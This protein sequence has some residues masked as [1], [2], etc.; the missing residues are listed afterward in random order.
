M[1]GRIEDGTVPGP[2]KR[3]VAGLL[4]GLTSKADSALVDCLSADGRRD[5]ERCAGAE[6][7]T[8]R[9]HLSAR[10]HAGPV[11]EPATFAQPVPFPTGGKDMRDRRTSWLLRGAIVT[12][13][14]C[15]TTEHAA[16]VEEPA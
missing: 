6:A 11:A 15:C 9:P 7:E 14:A 12:A 16:Q 5:V 2:F 4:R 1:Y 3:M 8:A 10:Q 13:V